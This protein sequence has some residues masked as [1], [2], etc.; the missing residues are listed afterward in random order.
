MHVIDSL[1]KAVIRK[2]AS[3]KHLNFFEFVWSDVSRSVFSVCVF[4][5]WFCTLLGIRGETSVVIVKV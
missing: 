1:Y 4:S 3:N 2:Q 5:S